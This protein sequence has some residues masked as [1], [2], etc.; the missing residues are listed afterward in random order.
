MYRRIFG[1]L[2]GFFVCLTE[3][4]AE[5]HGV[6]LGPAYMDA[7]ADAA[8]EAALIDPRSSYP[9]GRCPDTDYYRARV[10]ASHIERIRSRFMFQPT[11]PIV[12][13]ALLDA[14]A[15]SIALPLSVSPNVQRRKNESP[16]I[17]QRLTQ[18]AEIFL[19]SHP[20]ADLSMLP[21]KGP[22]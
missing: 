3:R 18:L 8:R 1:E 7:V 14:F 2:L 13:P 4:F 22:Q 11:E 12:A 15:W 20:L 16:V 5:R 10:F 19:K 17:R 6:M 9:P 21:G